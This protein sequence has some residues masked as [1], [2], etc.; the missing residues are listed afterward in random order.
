[1]GTYICPYCF[2]KNDEKDKVCK[3]CK[4]SLPYTFGKYQDETFSVVGMKDSG[5]STFIGMLLHDVFYSRI[6]E[7]FGASIAHVNDEVN[8]KTEYRY[9][10]NLEKKVTVDV[11]RNAV[12]NPD[13]K[14]PLI[15]TLSFS[16]KKLFGGTKFNVATMSLFDNAGEDL[17]SENNMSIANRNII[18]STGIIMIIDPLQFPAVRDE[19]K[20]KGIP[21][22]EKADR[23]IEKLL[24]N[25]VNL[26][27]N[28]RQPK[29][30]KQIDIPIAIALSKADVLADF[31]GENNSMIFGDSNYREV[32]DKKE[33]MG[34]SAEIENLIISYYNP[35][36]VQ[37]IKNTFKN[38]C[39]FGFSALGSNPVPDP[40]NDRKRGGK[41]I[42]EYRS[43]RVEDPFLW[44]LQQRNLIQMK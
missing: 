37:Q 13:I 29:S 38:Y 41:K 6:S 36:F 8:D 23:K 9:G 15:F 30:D 40:E 43:F 39:F 22:P 44:I 2:T 25:I 27:Q 7:Q 21:L 42:E 5:K 1:M 31:I 16:K 26:I 35:G 24:T 17:V 33:M 4:K 10:N 20:N 28:S 32:L 18:N 12:E 34:I 19:L 3:E 11:T 14:E